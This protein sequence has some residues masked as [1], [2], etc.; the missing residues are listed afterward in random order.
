MFNYSL[1]YLP[2][3]ALLLPLEVYIYTLWEYLLGV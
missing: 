3:E 1:A 2:P